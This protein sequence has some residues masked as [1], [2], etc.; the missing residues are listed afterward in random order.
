MKEHYANKKRNMEVFAFNPTS[1]NGSS[2]VAQCSSPQGRVEDRKYEQDCEEVLCLP[3]PAWTAHRAP[4]PHH[5]NLYDQQ[6]EACLPKERKKK[7][8]EDRH[9]RLPEQKHATNNNANKLLG[10]YSQPQSDPEMVKLSLWGR[11]SS[12]DIL[13]TEREESARWTATT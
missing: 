4:V 11:H 8:A 10:W 7:R 9:C 3:T 5:I 1:N 2:G 6:T 12:S 13:A